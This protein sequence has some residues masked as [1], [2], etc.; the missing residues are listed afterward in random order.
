MIQFE[1]KNKKKTWGGK[2]TKM[3]ILGLFLNCLPCK[4]EKYFQKNLATAE[5]DTIM[6][7][8]AFLNCPYMAKELIGEITYISLYHIL[9]II[10]ML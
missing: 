10:N 2:N 6:L 5:K 9:I 7:S 8:K 4:Y 1:G 3:S